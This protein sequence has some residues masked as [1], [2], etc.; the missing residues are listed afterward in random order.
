M[1][2]KNLIGVAKFLFDNYYVLEP[3]ENRLNFSL[4][5]RNHVKISSERGLDKLVFIEELHEP[6]HEITRVLNV[7][8]KQSTADLIIGDWQYSIYFK[9]KINHNNT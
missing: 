3:H 5:G 1:N 6:S 8:S 2:D 4:V 7:D 9:G